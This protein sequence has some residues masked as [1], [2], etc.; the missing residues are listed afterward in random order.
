M[1]LPLTKLAK[2]LNTF[3]GNWPWPLADLH[4]N[5]KEALKRIHVPAETRKLE[6]TLS[7][8]NQ[9]IVADCV[10]E[11]TKYMQKMVLQRMLEA[12]PNYLVDVSHRYV[13][14]SNQYTLEIVDT[15]I[16]VTDELIEFLKQKNLHVTT[17]P[18]KIL[19]M[20]NISPTD[21]SATPVSADSGSENDH[22]EDRGAF[23][24]VSESCILTFTVTGP[25]RIINECFRDGRA[26]AEMQSKKG[27]TISCN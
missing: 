8:P 10:A 13:L 21:D 23:K 27:I 16:P 18:A 7:G 9:E 5:V 11:V 3:D 22:C 4:C 12:M 24:S 25:T 1:F 6:F 15:K 20:Q 26:F 2:Y 17:I 19:A 14:L